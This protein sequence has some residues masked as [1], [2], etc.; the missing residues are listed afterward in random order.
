VIGPV[1]VS[2]G[3][4]RSLGLSSNRWPLKALVLTKH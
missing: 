1:N 4:F 2:G 3:D